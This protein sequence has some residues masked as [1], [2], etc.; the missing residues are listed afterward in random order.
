MKSSEI[1]KK[2]KKLVLTPEEVIIYSGMQ[3]QRYICLAINYIIVFEYND[4]LEGR[5]RA[6]LLKRYVEKAIGG[7]LIAEMYIKDNWPWY[8]RLFISKVS[9]KE[10]QTFRHNLLDKM[11]KEYEAIGD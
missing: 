3:E 11:I 5:V 8:K 7:R 2:V 6:E 9:L 4:L 10:A 1:L